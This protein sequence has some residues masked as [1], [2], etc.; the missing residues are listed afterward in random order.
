MVAVGA[1]VTARFAWRSVARTHPGHVRPTNEDAYIADDRLGLFL[2]ADGMGGHA[3]GEVASRIA[4]EAVVAVVQED[5]T[6]DTDPP[7]LLRRAI[8]VAYD[9]IVAYARAHAEASDLG[10]TLTA[11]LLR[12]SGRYA[13]AHLGDS[14]AYL[15]RGG[16]LRRLTRDHTYVQALVEAGRLR[17]EVAARHPLRHVLLHVLS[18]QGWSEPDVRAGTLQPGDLWVLATDGLTNVVDDATLAAILDA[19]TPL[20]ERAEALVTLANHRGGPD[21]ITVVLVEVHAV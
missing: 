14:R 2:V 20:D 3:A 5:P 12:P 10:T 6:R 7:A 17:P 8:R 21:N 11:L 16:E 18:A 13:L 9:R 19:P 4:A 1:P 15:R